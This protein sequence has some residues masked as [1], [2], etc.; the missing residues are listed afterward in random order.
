MGRLTEETLEPIAQTNMERMLSILEQQALNSAV[1]NERTAP[2][3][4]PN[5][6]VV[7]LFLQENGEPWSKSLK[8]DI[9]FGSIHFN[10]TPLT[11][12]E[13][14]ALN[15]LQPLARGTVTKTDGSTLLVGV[16]PKVDATGRLNRLTISPYVAPGQNPGDAR[17]E[18]NLNL[19]LPSIIAIANELAG[20]ATPMVAA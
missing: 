13:V 20:Q 10:E 9:Y 8:C 3:E 16:L 2:R 6:K 19:T 15:Q 4:N 12:V 17:F 11:K 7:S 18:K 5:Y 1:Q 14:D